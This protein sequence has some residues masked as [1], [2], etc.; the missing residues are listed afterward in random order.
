M[1]ALILAAGFGTRLG[2]L[3]K[4]TPKALIKVG[5]TSILDI[6]IRK[7]IQI[8]ISEILINTHYLADQIEKYLVTQVYP[9]KVSTFFEPELLGTAGTLKARLSLFEHDDFLWVI[10]KAPLRSIRGGACGVEVKDLLLG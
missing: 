5:S 6:N 8:G 4:D 3:T 1:K 10:K 9:V 2:S 7:L